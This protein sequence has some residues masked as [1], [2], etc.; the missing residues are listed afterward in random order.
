MNTVG[1]VAGSGVT[2]WPVTRYS[3]PRVVDSTKEKGLLLGPELI[4]SVPVA[5]F[6]DVSHS[7]LSSSEG[8]G[9]ISSMTVAPESFARTGKLTVPSVGEA[10]RVTSQ[11]VYVPVNWSHENDPVIAPP[12]ATVVSLKYHVVACTG[13][14]S[15]AMNPSQ[16]GIA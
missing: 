9:P 16:T 2:I 7:S 13:K 3:A 14:P 4:V 1:A 6:R 8:L 11:D 15:R 10:S 12:P 5:V